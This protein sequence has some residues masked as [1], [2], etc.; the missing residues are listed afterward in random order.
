MLV[1]Y[2]PQKERQHVCISHVDLYV[3]LHIR[4]V[5]CKLGE[6]LPVVLCGVLQIKDSVTFRQ[7]QQWHARHQ[8]VAVDAHQ[9][10]AVDAHQ[11][12]AVDALEATQRLA[13]LQTF[14]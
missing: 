3:R 5:L 7:I 12:V 10:A 9:I 13:C 1:I 11:I 2:K 6:G 8:I 14:D 4:T